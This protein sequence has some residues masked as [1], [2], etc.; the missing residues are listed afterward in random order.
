MCLIALAYRCHPRYPLIVAANRDEFYQRPSA[1]AAFW[2]DHPHVLAGKDLEHQGT[3]LGITADGRFSAITNYRDPAAIKANAKSRGEI[4]SNFLYG[5]QAPAEYLTKVDLAKNEYNGFNLIAGDSSGLY[6]YSN[7]TG[8]IKTVEPGI[9][10]LSNHLLDTP[11]PKVEKIKAD[12]GLY[13]ENTA[14]IDEEQLFSLLADAKRPADDKLP[15][16]GVSLDWERLLSAIYIEGE[17]YGTR[18]STIILQ[19]KSGHV[20]FIERTKPSNRD[21]RYE[22]DLS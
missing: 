14:I 8:V 6:Y 11:W 12:L 18:C 15:A 20:R 5:Q 1:P 17:N 9:H 19:D 13:L 4:V 16:T 2:T 10:A 21:V 7:R 22:F 3:W